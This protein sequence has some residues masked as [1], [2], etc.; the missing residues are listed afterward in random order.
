M[1]FKLTQK[2]AIRKTKSKGRVACNV[3][4]LLG[5][6]DGSKGSAVI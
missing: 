1:I 5:I 4:A 3:S 6:I 2:D